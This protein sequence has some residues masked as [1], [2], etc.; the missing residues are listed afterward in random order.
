MSHAKNV[1]ISRDEERWEL[2]LKAEIPAEAIHSYRSAAVKEI[3]A[4]ATI[5]G[6]RKGKAPESVLVKHFGEQAILQEAAE[7]AVKHELPEILAKEEAN[8]VEAP[9]V[10]ISHPEAGKSVEF[11]ARAPL[12]PEV[13][14]P[15][16][17][18]IA[19]KVNKEKKEESVSDEE[20]AQALTHLKRERARIDAIENG[21]NPQEAAD[22][23]KKI[24]EKDLPALDDMF[25]Q[26][27][28]YESAEKFTSAVRENMKTE[29][30]MRETEKRRAQLLDELV[31]QSTIKYPLI[32]KEY[33]LDDMEARM[34]SDIERMGTTLDAYL[35]STKKTKE[36]LRKEWLP[37]ADQRAKVRLVLS[38]IA[39]VEHIEPD[40]EALAHEVEHAKEHVKDASESALRAHISHT[41]R[42][43]AVI[44]F[45]EGNEPKKHDHS[46]EGHNHNH[47]H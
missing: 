31:Q 41:M 36:D 21:K 29:K 10:T 20:H 26:S 28:G 46:H 4:A 33:E 17:K 9:R 8:I 11:T 13:K 35:T 6:F 3:A 42:N 1:K 38:E 2:E 25:A 27:V 37:A 40:P 18:K 5:P 39:R 45:L 32:L 43:E 47:G 44:N 19:E 24:E 22:E 30:E 16:Y 23:V 7:Q 34:G 12:A 14:L 15:D